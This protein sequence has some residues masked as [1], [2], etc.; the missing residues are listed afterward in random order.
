MSFICGES[1][2][3]L[4]STVIS[5]SR[6]PKRNSSLSMYSALSCR[7][8]G[9]LAA[10]SGKEAEC[11]KRRRQALK[12]VDR[13]LSRGNFKV[14][15]SLVKQLQRKPAGGLRGFGAAKQVFFFPFQSLRDSRIRINLCI[16]IRAR[17]YF[18]V[19]A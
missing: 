4:S 2:T 7:F 15:L 17:A 5:F 18:C 12:R 3:A 19:G 14:A 11:A 16:F 13:E 10:A 1:S 8:G 6:E 9:E